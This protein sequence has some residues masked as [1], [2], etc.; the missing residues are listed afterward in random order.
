MIRKE[1]VQGGLSSVQAQAVG[2]GYADIVAAGSVQGDG[3]TVAVSS[4]IVTAADGTK[5]VTLSGDVGDEIWM[6]NNAAS[7]L[8]VYPDTGAAINV[9]GTG[10][11]TVNAAFS[12][13]TFKVCVYKKVTS[14]KWLVIVT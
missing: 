8:K 9:T 11:G 7:T 3:T 10:T 5:G 12:H 4:T 14:T 6:F 2:G 13:L 1:M